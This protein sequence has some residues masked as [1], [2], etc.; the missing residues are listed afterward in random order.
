MDAKDGRSFTRFAGSCITLA[1][2]AVFSLAPAA[3]SEGYLE[4]SSEASCDA[5]FPV[6]T[7]PGA[8][9]FGPNGSYVVG[10]DESCNASR[11]IDQDNDKQ[12]PP[13]PPH[14]VEIQVKNYSWP[15]AK[16]Q[17]TLAGSCQSASISEPGLRATNYGKSPMS[18]LAVALPASGKHAYRY[19]GDSMKN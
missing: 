15:S 14:I 16:T 11:M 18:H 2:L 4:A 6:I 8:T 17:S 1:A 13:E 7:G 9:V 19:L 5:G 10:E 3:F 12:S